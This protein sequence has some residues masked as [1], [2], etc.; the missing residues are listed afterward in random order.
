MIYDCFVFYNELD[1]LE[2][3]LSF[4]DNYVDYFVICECSHT[5]KGKQKQFFLENNL[6]HYSKYINKIIYLKADN[7]PIEKLKND[8]WAIEFYQRD[9]LINGLSKC[10]ND[11]LV[12]ISDVDEFWNPIILKN[13]TLC[14][15]KLVDIKTG[16]RNYL[17]IHK[18]HFLHSPSFL[19]KHSFSYFIDKTPI[20]IEQDFFYYFFNYKWSKKWHGTII[21]KYKNLESPQTLRNKRNLLPYICSNKYKTGW[22]FSYLGGKEKIKEKLSCIVEGNLCTVENIDEWIDFCLKNKEDLFNRNTDK[23]SIIDIDELGIDVITTWIEK[24]PNFFL[25][26]NS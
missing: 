26:I 13:T 7:P 21:T 4:Y 6:S 16:I 1:I 5:Q 17:G 10:N 9:Y 23:L 18:Y 12:F 20:A 14:S 11:D 19:F 2:M 22:H 25:N 24:F 8:P 3:R 15:V